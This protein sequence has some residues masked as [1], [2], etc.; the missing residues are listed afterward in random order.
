SGSRAPMPRV[1]NAGRTTR[2]TNTAFGAISW[3]GG[4]STRVLSRPRGGRTRSPA[5]CASR[6]GSRAPM[7]RAPNA[8]QT[9]RPTNAGR[10][11]EKGAAGLPAAPRRRTRGVRARR[12]E[13]VRGSEQH[14]A[15]VLLVLVGAIG[16]AA[17]RLVR[18]V[19]QVADRQVEAQVLH[20]T[21]LER[22]AQL[23]VDHALA[24]HVAQRA[25]VGEVGDLADERRALAL[26]DPSLE[27][28]LLVVEGQV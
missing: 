11:K 3:L 6:S 2:P 5:A 28:G 21:V 4:R 1:P 9:T 7:P 13:L 15:A 18:R 10:G 14:G 24:H 8:G 20:R 16:A 25:V 22:V 23:H 27:T 19:V 12:S 17:I 26:A